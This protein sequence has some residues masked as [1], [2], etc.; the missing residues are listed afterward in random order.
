MAKL[1]ALDAQYGD[2][3]IVHY[4]TPANGGDPAIPQ[5]WLIDGGPTATY[6]GDKKKNLKP[7]LR[8]RLNKLGGSDEKG[9]RF[10]LG[11]VT[12]IDDDHIDGIR[13]LTQAMAAV[14]QPKCTPNV[15]FDDF[16]FNG[17]E[18]TF[19]SGGGAATTKT[20]T[21]MMQLQS[22]GD[23][24]PDGLSFDDPVA[25][26]ALLQ[27]VQDGV[28]LMDDLKRLEQDGVLPGL[29]MAFSAAGFPAKA[30]AHDGLGALDLDGAKAAIL[31]PTQ[32]QLDKL[33][34]EWAD[35]TG[36]NAA[37]LAGAAKKVK[38]DD[39]V[40]NLSS[41]V[42]LATFKGSAG[43]KSMLLT[44]DG[45]AHLIIEGWRRHVNK[46]T[47]DLAPHDID[48]MKVP[49]HGSD[50]NNTTELF[51][52]FPAKH[53][54]FCANGKHKNPDMGTLKLLFAARSLAGDTAAYKLHLTCTEDN[55][56]TAEQA[57]FIKK[58]AAE[59]GGRVTFRFRKKDETS[60]TI[61]E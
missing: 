9:L 45:V 10:R 58:M 44:G 40:A 2:C 54:V 39:A 13:Q 55:A 36:V 35:K 30:M 6:G 20:K 29:N 21:Q 11:V 28:E 57:E 52:L 51:N 49:H 7:V 50:A 43:A 1:E 18:E 14:P 59:S 33:K 15:R 53:Y 22:A 4:E 37:T 19:G 56:A 32:D 27:S 26:Q 16:W 31:C 12:H 17:F 48:I 8:D 25:A 41:I 23:L 34:Q 47:G 38:I 5:K 3:L 42:M 24:L 61:P 60:I 46:L